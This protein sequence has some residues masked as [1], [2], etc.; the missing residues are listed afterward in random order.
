MHTNKKKRRIIL[1]LI[2]IILCFIWGNSITPAPISKEFSSWFK[3]IIN[4]LLD[5][6]GSDKTLS[7]GGVLRK[8]AH[9][10]EFAALG[11]VLTLLMEEGRKIKVSLLALSGLGAALIDETIQLFVVGRSGQIKDVWIDLAGF[12]IGVAIVGLLFHLVNSRK[13]KKLL[14]VNNEK[15]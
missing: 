5:D 2:A 6:V 1:V 7:S 13:N 10:S 14:R 11:M 8:I 12:A 4:M 3:D 9:A 15:H